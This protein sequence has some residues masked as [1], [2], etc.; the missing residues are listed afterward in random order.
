MQDV[1]TDKITLGNIAENLRRLRAERGLSYSELARRC[2]VEVDGER[3]TAYPATIERI[4][5]G[6]HMPS[7][8][9]AKRIAEALGVSLDDL[10]EA[11][12]KIPA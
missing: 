9:L 6:K 8:S 7:T 5:K 2:S 10:T 11:R 1:E 3:N 12:E 4:E